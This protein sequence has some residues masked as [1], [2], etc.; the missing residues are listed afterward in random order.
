MNH[1]FFTRF[2]SVLPALA[3]ILFGTSATL[4]AAETQPSRPNVVFILA[5][6]WGWGDLGCYGH[7][8][9]RTPHLDR[10]ASQGTRFTQFYS[11][12]SV[13]SPSRVA[14]MTGRFPARTG[15]HGHLDTPESNARRGMPNFLDPAIPTL[16]RLLQRAGY[17]TAHIG[18]WH[19]GHSPDAPQPS[20]Y[21]FDDVSGVLMNQKRPDPQDGRFRPQST[22]V[23]VDETIAFIEKNRDRP[24]YVQ[25]W[26]LDTH[27]RLQPTPE[28]LAAYPNLLGATRIYYAAATDADKQLGRLFAKLD[29]LGLANNTIVIFSSD[30]GPEEILIGN[31]SEHG[32]G[33]PG[34]FRGRKRS[35]YDGGI[36]MP[37]I[38][39]WP[40]HTPAGRVDNE[41]V[42]CAADFLP[43]I[44][45]L[46]GV[47]PGD[48]GQ[49]LDGQSVAAAW[50]G[51]KLGSRRPILWEWRFGIFGHVINMSPMLAIRD[52]NYKLLMNPDRSR[53]ELYDIPADPSELTNLAAGHPEVVERL[54]APLLKWQSELPKSPYDETA[55][56]NRYPWP[57]EMPNRR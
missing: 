57:R 22:R 28:Q 16:P 37:F 54:A 11:C 18:K 20:T 35:L 52:G 30:N 8:S 34:P 43:T 44:C 39:R 10:L 40:G 14:W 51:E 9:L 17:A 53:V 29:E 56:Q 5:D 38:L 1:R 13:C 32:V 26:L 47:D 49:K 41:S 19:L 42:V 27:A 25:T 55:G 23:F 48:A 2:L 36:R 50:R 33:S 12:A 24:F 7:R 46:A 6:D 3:V 31:A 15:I 21:G 45:E 4:A